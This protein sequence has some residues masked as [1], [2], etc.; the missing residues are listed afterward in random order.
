MKTGEKAE[1][2]PHVSVFGEPITIFLGKSDSLRAEGVKR[3]MTCTEEQVSL[4]LRSGSLHVFGKR[5]V[6]VTF[7]S[8]AVEIT[9]KIERIGNERREAREDSHS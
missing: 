5:L 6:C 2:R 7:C 9:G 3:I 4:R 8:G 1:K